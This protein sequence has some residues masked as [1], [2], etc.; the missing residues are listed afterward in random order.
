MTSRN[1]YRTAQA[2]AGLRAFAT[3]VPPCAGGLLMGQSPEHRESED[4][5]DPG[6]QSV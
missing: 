1:A 4:R 5:P 3:A 2:L 6:G